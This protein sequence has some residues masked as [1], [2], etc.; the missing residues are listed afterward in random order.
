MLG[1]STPRAP[2][3]RCTCLAQTLGA[4]HQPAVTHS[5]LRLD[6][7][8]HSGL[9]CVLQRGSELCWAGGH[10]A[11]S[12]ARK[13]EE[14]GGKPE[15]SFGAGDEDLP[16]PFLPSA[17]ELGISLPEEKPNFRK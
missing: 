4:R 2:L 17:A 7:P 6:A 8:G 11:C 1:P 10:C 3:K 5:H 14:P 12:R 16:P 13:G 9:D 15:P